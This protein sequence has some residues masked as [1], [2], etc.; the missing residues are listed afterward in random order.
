MTLDP[1]HDTEPATTTT[2]DKR[3][4]QRMVIAALALILFLAGMC[5][6][7][8]PLAFVLGVIV[9]I[10]AQRWDNRARPDAPIPLYVYVL[11]SLIA[12]AIVAVLAIAM[13]LLP[14][15]AAS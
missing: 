3:A 10:T 5:A 7:G 15:E 11:T 9:T 1:P 13:V 6:I 8:T 4:H 14:V 12:L 2:V